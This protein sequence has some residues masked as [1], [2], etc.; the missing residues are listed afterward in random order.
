L[1]PTSSAIPNSCRGASARGSRAAPDLIVAD[2]IIGFRMFR[3]RFNLA[4]DARPAAPHRC[5]LYRGP[6][7]YL[8][9]HWVFEPV[10]GGCRARFLCRFEFK[11]RILQ[12]VIELLFHEAVRRM[13]AAFEQRAQRLYGA[14][15][16]SEPAKA[17]V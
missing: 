10:V 14:R 5:C 2:L 7:R 11:S 1:W 12:R 6:F 16:R 4:R 9:N 8:N 15:R 17:A 3:E 13:V